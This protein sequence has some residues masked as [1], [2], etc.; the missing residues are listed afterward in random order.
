MEASEEQNQDGDLVRWK[1]F[2]NESSNQHGYGAGLVLQSSL[3][4]QVE[5][6]IRIGFKATNNEAEYEALLASLRV[7]IELK[8]K[9]LDIYSDSQFAVISMKTKDFKIFQI[10]IKE[11]KKA[12]VQANLAS[13]FDF[14]SDRSVP[15]EFLPNL[16]IDIAKIICQATTNPTWMDDIITYLKDGELLSNKL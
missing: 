13:A 15:Q 12:D 3:G 10:P 2:I 1:L 8:V 16:S 7:L 11:N 4:E 14:T 9:S 5:Y 6:A